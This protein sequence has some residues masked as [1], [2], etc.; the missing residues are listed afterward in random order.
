MAWEE[1]KRKQNI[2]SGS[3]CN[4]SWQRSILRKPLEKNLPAERDWK[5]GNAISYNFRPW[6][7]DSLMLE[8]PLDLILAELKGITCILEAGCIPWNKTSTAKPH[9]NWKSSASSVTMRCVDI[10]DLSENSSTLWFTGI[11]SRTKAC[12]MTGHASSRQGC[13]LLDTVCGRISS[14]NEHCCGKFKILLEDRGAQG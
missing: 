3:T 14:K 6:N 2:W 5:T 1:F 8:S 11:A 12:R 7:E 10:K 4:S 9:R 13:S